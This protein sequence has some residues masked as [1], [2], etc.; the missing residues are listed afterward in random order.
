MIVTSLS[1][2]TTNIPA[3]IRGSVAGCYT[4][5]GGLGV[6][7]MTKIGGLLFD[8]WKP[9][10]PFLVIGIVSAI[11]AVSGTVYLL[12]RKKPE[13]H[14]QPVPTTPVNVTEHNENEK[15]IIDE[16]Q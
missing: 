5:F 16:Q 9:T 4:F 7:F 3:D 6:L 10:A 8:S 12:L 1:Q 2:A 13:H 15:Y 11:A 14:Q